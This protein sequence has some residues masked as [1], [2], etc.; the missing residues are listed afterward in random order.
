MTYSDAGQFE[1]AA[2]FLRRS[3]E[4]SKPDESHLRKAY[5]LLVHAEVRQG[6]R[7]GTGD[8]PA[9][10][11]LFPQDIELRFREGVVLHELGRLEESG[12]LPRRAGR[13]RG[14][15]LHQH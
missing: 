6:L 2:E 14:A 12:S 7:K 13:A 10:A 3:I 4:H 11:E 8:M 9:G 1:E 15:A 5:A